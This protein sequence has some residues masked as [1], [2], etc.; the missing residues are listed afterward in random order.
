MSEIFKSSAE[1]SGEQS[2]PK[3]VM[4]EMEELIMQKYPFEQNDDVKKIWAENVAEFLKNNPTAVKT[5]FKDFLEQWGSA[6]LRDAEA[7]RGAVGDL[8]LV[9]TELA[10]LANDNERE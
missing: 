4:E 5:F 8:S 6:D 2:L 9:S 1:K 3:E 7:V 10:K